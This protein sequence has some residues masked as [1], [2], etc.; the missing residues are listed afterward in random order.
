MRQRET[1][2]PRICSGLAHEVGAEKCLR[3]AFAGGIAHQH[4]TDRRR[5]QSGVIPDRDA[6]DDF[7]LALP[8]A[9]PLCHGDRR[10]DGPW[11]GQHG[12]E[13]WQPPAFQ[14]WPAHLSRPTWRGRGEQVGIDPQ[15]CD[16]ADLAADRCDQ[17]EGGEAGV[18][19]DD[20][21]AIRQPALDLSNGSVQK[22]AFANCGSGLETGSNSWPNPEPSTPL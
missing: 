11:I 19:D 22:L 14:P 16:Q 18:G 15:P 1:N 2:Q 9:V 3:F 17:V 10:P 21:A 7:Q 13:F 20:E 8:T 5:R 4:P 6:G 12:S